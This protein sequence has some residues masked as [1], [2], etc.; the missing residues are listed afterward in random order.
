MNTVQVKVPELSESVSE[1]TLLEWKRKPGDIVAADEI[2]IEIETDKVVLEVP[3]PAAGQL[4]E[5]RAQN[6]Q[7]VVSGEVIAVIDTDASVSASASTDSS[8]A[9]SPAP[10]KETVA[11]PR[12][13]PSAAAVLAAA[14]VD[15]KTVIG[16][17]PGN[18]ITKVD[19]LAAAEPPVQ[20]QAAE[21]APRAVPAPRSAAAPAPAEPIAPDPYGRKEDRVPMTRLRRRVAERLVQSLA[22]SAQ[23]TTFNEVDMSA[24]IALR[25][26][27][28]E[29]FERRHGIKLGFMSFF[30]KAAVYALEKFPV[31]NASIDGTDIIYHS[32][33]DIGVAVG[34]ERGL[35]VPV[36]RN[37]DQKTFAEIELEIADFAKRAQ[38]GKLSIEELSGGTFTVSNGGV[39][40]SMLSTP[41]INPPQS[42]ILGIHA[43]KERPVVVNGE[44][45]IRPMN[46]LALSYDHRLIDGREAVQGLGAMKAA[47]E[48][49]A[50]MLLDI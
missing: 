9:S 37:A 23:L 15:A 45:V 6:G 5:I 24:I 1:A 42:A 8:R 47:L 4:A 29:K 39:F 44:I 33:F 30:V 48:D 7:T 18:R 31:L 32:Y 40:G 11:E 28:K 20:P 25:A 21:P 2:L 26:R 50:V 14:G 35:V 41:I 10:V 46:Y 49:P 13:M 3:S 43:T 36:V 19:A 34:T 22:G 16:T 12:V 27:Y 17:G 38:A